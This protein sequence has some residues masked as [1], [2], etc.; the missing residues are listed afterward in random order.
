[1]LLSTMTRLARNTHTQCED[2]QLSPD[3]SVLARSVCNHR[4]TKHYALGVR[5][6]LQVRVLFEC[7][8]WEVRPGVTRGEP[9]DVQ[10]RTFGFETDAV[11]KK[12]SGTVHDACGEAW[13]VR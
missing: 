11:R 12:F 2:V 6:L 5:S 7:M 13:E 3:V 4:A 8:S 10:I 1:M 9:H